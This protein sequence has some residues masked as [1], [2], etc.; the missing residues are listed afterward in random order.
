MLHT[1]IKHDLKALQAFV[2]IVECQ[3]V[4]AAQKRLNMSQS[5]IS[6]HLAHLEE[7]LG[8]VLCRRGR[9]GFAL[10]KAGH[11][12]Y[13]ACT[14][15][16]QATSEFHREVQNIKWHRSVLSGTLRIGLVEY[17]PVDFQNI[18]NRVIASAYQHYPELRLSI[19]ICAPQDIEIAIANNQMDFGV[20]YYYSLLKNLHYQLVFEEREYIFC[21]ISHPAAKVSDLTLNLLSEDYQWVKRIYARQQEGNSLMTG[22]TTA[23]AHKQQATLMFILA[24]S[25]LGLLS[26][27]VA[28]SYVR[29]GVLIPLL[30]QQAANIVNYFA[31]TRPTPDPRVNWFLGEL[32]GLLP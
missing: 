25:H 26:E 22:N 3:G 23:V 28:E 16:L 9:S 6:T 10:T 24:G 11:Q 13:E 4:T 19:D 18:L 12:L 30:T 29:S 27:E 14:L 32:S 8:V 1:L 31:V 5:A 20:G 7:S 17:L 21:H 2:A 15:L